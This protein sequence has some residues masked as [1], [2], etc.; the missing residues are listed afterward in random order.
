MIIY[1]FLLLSLI[2]C[3][4]NGISFDPFTDKTEIT[5]H[6]G[7]ILTGKV[8]LM[9]IWYGDENDNVHKNLIR[10]FVKSLNKER[11]SATK[12][13]QPQVKTWWKVVESYQ[14]L[15]PGAKS[16]EPPDIKVVA[17]KQKSTNPKYGKVL[18]QQIIIPNLIEAVTH[19]DTGLLPVIIA[20]RD[21]TVQ[22]LCAGK[23]ADKG[24]LE[25]NQSYIV[26][27]NPETECPG[28]CGWPFFEADSGPKGPVLKPPNQNM[29]G[30]AMV[31]AF[32]GALVDTVLSPKNSGFFGGNEFEPFGPATVCR[33]IFGEDAA[34]GHPG[35][36]LTDSK[37]GG[38]YN[39]I[40]NE[41][42]RFLVPAIWNP[43]TKSCWTPMMKE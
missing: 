10:N 43:K 1:L 41:G 21:V 19:G 36:V 23:C 11:K 42:K 12:K 4:S 8:N 25:N 26:V 30:D 5:Y 24:V 38:N 34:P 3:I 7:P 35:K 37:E 33:G 20:A 14:S 13:G 15:L 2:P 28:A 22:G 9:L 18:T 32:A 17:E 31:A 40:G 16:G 29:A 6:G 39:A 27:G